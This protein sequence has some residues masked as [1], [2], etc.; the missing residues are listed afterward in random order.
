MLVSK[1]SEFTFGSQD[2]FPPAYSK[3]IAACREAMKAILTPVLKI[4]VI[5][6]Y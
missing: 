3:E 4:S 1:I 6:R 5:Y 2:K